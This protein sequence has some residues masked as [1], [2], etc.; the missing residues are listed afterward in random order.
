MTQA[1]SK[2]II[3]VGVSGDMPVEGFLKGFEL[4]IAQPRPQLR[5]GGFV[6]LLG[7]AKFRELTAKG[8]DLLGDVGVVKEQCGENVSHRKQ[9]L[10]MSLLLAYYKRV[11]CSYQGAGGVYGEIF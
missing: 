10:Y 5:G 7:L 4:R 11:Y 6:V 9:L 8:I 1:Q 3:G 2:E